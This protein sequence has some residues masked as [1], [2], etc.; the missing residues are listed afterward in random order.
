MSH[1]DGFFTRLA[2]AQAQK[3]SHLMAGIDPR[4]PTDEHVF[5]KSEWVRLGAYKYL[6][7]Y[8]R[9]LIAACKEDAASVKLQSAF[10]EQHGPEG[11]RALQEAITEASAQNML[12]LLDAKRGDISSTMQAY[13]KASFEALGA[14]AL[15][16]Q[17]YMGTDV[18][19][20]FFDGGFYRDHGVYV[21]LYSSN[22]SAKELQR[23]TLRSGQSML[24]HFTGAIED[25]CGSDAGKLASIGY[26]IGATN[27]ADSWSELDL[28]KHS[29]ILPGVGAQGG[30]VSP[31]TFEQCRA[32][33]SSVP[34][35]RGLLRDCESVQ[36]W[37]EF[38]VFV[39]GNARELKEQVGWGDS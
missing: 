4:V 20:P 36:T 34:V 28:K 9:R 12:T 26:V 31:K 7:E 22:P 2:E 33:S 18:L 30:S 35:S 25:V 6:G 3:K 13:Y 16:V 8:T 17:L 5:L 10:F 32:A 24:A 39:R 15:T 27:P 29:L 11:I 37:D 38:E 23:Q 1:G 19:K 21:V 14:D